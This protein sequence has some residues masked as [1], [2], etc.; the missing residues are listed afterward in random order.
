MRLNGKKLLDLMRD[1]SLT[2]EMIC[3][4]T[5]LYRKSLQWILDSGFVSMEAAERIA[6][7]VGI[8]AKKI[9]L[10]DAMMDVE[11]AIEFTKDSDRATVSFSQGRYIGRIRKLAAA[12]PEE[13]EIMTENKDG[14]ICA[15]IPV[16]WV[17]ISPPK[18]YTEEQRQKMAVRLQR[19]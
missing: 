6:E 16:N 13:C 12:R 5:G 3:S 4:R 17:K 7:A 1:K 2:D 9:L 15:H 18:K 14:S 11:N 19:K 10:P 8:E